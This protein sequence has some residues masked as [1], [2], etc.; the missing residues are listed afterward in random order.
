M[1]AREEAIK[2]RNISEQAFKQGNYDKVMRF[3]FTKH[4]SQAMRFIEKSIRICPT[5]EAET[6]LKTLKRNEPPPVKTFTKVQEVLCTRILA[7]TDLYSVLDVGR[8]S[9]D[10][11]IK[12]AYRKVSRFASESI[13]IVQMALQLHPDK[14]GAPRAEDAFK[15]ISNAFQTLSDPKKRSHYD[16]TGDEHV[17]SSTTTRSATSYSGD[18][19]IDPEELFRAFFGVGLDGFGSGATIY[20][21]ADGQTFRRVQTE[22]VN[23]SP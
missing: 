6:L 23:L 5:V 12:K 22:R 19:F 20:R 16:R 1:E 21:T 15:R 14:N 13:C 18:G 8:D 17:G 9:S 10:E 7:A 4:L 2:C 11:E 3:K